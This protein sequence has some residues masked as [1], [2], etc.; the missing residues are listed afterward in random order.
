MFTYVKYISVYFHV[1]HVDRILAK[2]KTIEE[3]DNSSVN[4]QVRFAYLS[5]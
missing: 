1:Y 5:T 4:S 3:F 2:L